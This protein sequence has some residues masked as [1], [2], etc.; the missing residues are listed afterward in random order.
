VGG[1]NH[2][3]WESEGEWGWQMTRLRR[4]DGGDIDKSAG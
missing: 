3:N 1:A 2:E 4:C